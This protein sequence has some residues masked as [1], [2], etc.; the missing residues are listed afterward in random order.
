MGRVASESRFQV[1]TSPSSQRIFTAA[2]L[3]QV[4][5]PPMPSSVQRTRVPMRRAGRVFFFLL[6]LGLLGRGS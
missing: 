6:M 5:R 4:I 1:I 2:A 3:A